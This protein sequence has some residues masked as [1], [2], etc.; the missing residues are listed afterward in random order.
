MWLAPFVLSFGW[1]LSFRSIVISPPGTNHLNIFRA[2]TVDSSRGIP[3]RLFDNLE[4]DPFCAGKAPIALATLP[5]RAGQT[6]SVA[7]RSMIETIVKVGA[8]F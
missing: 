1:P 5:A 2:R 6:L 3:S 4:T 8:G 7:V